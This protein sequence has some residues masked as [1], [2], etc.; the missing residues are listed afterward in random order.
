M[1]D[2]HH[3]RSDVTDWQTKRR[4]S[5]G[6][7]VARI[8]TAAETLCARYGSGKTNVCD[9]AT[10]LNMS[11]ANVYRFFPSKLAIYDAL[12]ARVLDNNFPVLRPGSGTLTGAESLRAFI[13]ELHRRVLALMHEEAN[14]FE[15]LT[16]ADDERWPAFE[17]HAKRVRAI[18]AEFVEVGVRE[19]EFRQ[20]DSLRAAECLCASTAALWEP[21]AIKNFHFRRSI[22][23]PEDLVSFSIEALRVSGRGVRAPG[24]G[25]GAGG[26]PSHLELP[27]LPK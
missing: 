9:I 2:S 26:S 1:L 4:E 7:N 8:L 3:Y 14:L 22:T 23:T 24:T 5:R 16:H 20:Q 21:K 18:V 15:L 12:V 25:D 27:R 11:P 13:L 17:A 19:Q 6:A 10:Y